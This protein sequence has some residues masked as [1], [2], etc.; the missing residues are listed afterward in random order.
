MASNCL[1]LLNNLIITF[2]NTIHTPFS[3]DF[4]KITELSTG[5]YGETIEIE[6]LFTECIC[7]KKLKK[8]FATNLH[9]ER[10][11][12]CDLCNTTVKN[13][14]TFWRCTEESDS[15]HKEGYTICDC[16]IIR[17]CDGNIKHCPYYTRLSS[18]IHAYNKDIMQTEIQINSTN[19]LQIQNDYLHLLET[20]QSD[21]EWEFIA[22]CL[23]YCDISE[24]VMFRRNN[25]NRNIFH[26]TDNKTNG[27]Y[28]NNVFSEIMDKIHCCF[29]HCYDIGHRLLIDERY[30]IEK[31]QTCNVF[32][33]NVSIQ[34]LL[35]SNQLLKINK[36]LSCK[37]KL[38]ERLYAG[39]L[40]VK[41]DQLMTEI[42]ESK[43]DDN[44]QQSMYCFGIRFNYGEN[45]DW[46]GDISV[47]PKYSSLKSEM[48][49]NSFCS[50]TI[51]QFNNE[52]NKA[53]I[54]FASFYC[55][56]HFAPQRIYD[57]QEYKYFKIEYLLS[58]MIYCNFDTLQNVFSK[59]Y[60]ENNGA[61]H[62]EF[63]HLGKYLKMATKKFGTSRKY[64]SEG[65]R[66]QFHHGISEKLFFPQ[67]FQNLMINGPLSTTTDILVAYNFTNNNKGLVV[68][69]VRYL[70][71]GMGHTTSAPKYFSCDWLSDFPSEKECLFIQEWE[72][73]TINNIIDVKIACEYKSI[74]TAMEKIDRAFESAIHV[75]EIAKDIQILVKAVINHQLS[76]STIKTLEKYG[77]NLI[78]TYF[79]NRTRVTIW[80][81]EIVNNKHISCA[82]EIFLHSTFKWVKLK[83]INLL[84]PKLKYIECWH[85]TFSH[86][87]LDDV[88]SNVDYFNLQTICIVIGEVDNA[89]KPQC[90]GSHGLCKFSTPHEGYGCDV[91][92]DT[93]RAN[94]DMWGCRVCNY[95]LCERCYE[96]ENK[97]FNTYAAIKICKQYSDRF[98]KNGL[99]I[100][101]YENSRLYIDKLDV[102]VYSLKWIEREKLA[103]FDN[104]GT[105]LHQPT[106]TLIEA[107]LSGNDNMKHKLFNDWC[108]HKGSFSIDWE[109]MNQPNNS[110]L[111]SILC[112]KEY[113]WIKIKKINLLFPNL[114]HLSVSGIKLC[115]STIINILEHLDDKNTKLEAITIDYT[116]DDESYCSDTIVLQ[117]NKQFEEKG[118]QIEKKTT[119]NC[120]NKHSKYA[121]RIAKI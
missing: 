27:D 116:N 67:Y 49:K 22:K 86:L 70:A 45:P 60:R 59:T 82:L 73:L 39:R 41:Y 97:K 96:K 111:L 11:V 68:T 47:S 115:T 81:D 1:R 85:T 83:E 16:C 110:H 69:F 64:D 84:Y 77:T 33:D 72:K 43:S 58:L 78:R 119:R 71:G 17:Y 34:Q 99:F 93:M 102:L 109:V 23:G 66:Q 108:L 15:V 101:F 94:R 103:Y 28:C 12:R 29:Q 7:G 46:Y 105:E 48:V 6:P 20:H 13:N 65:Y 91:C 100:A 87:V 61:D 121:V 95:D 4:I 88:L 50:L 107:Q 114:G 37:R 76:V 53:Q 56:K 55:K 92:N 51:D 117:Y 32:N 3:D 42:S 113:E 112:C 14:N 52:Y 118:W 63:Y 8:F 89:A 30:L 57:H 25:R 74:L 79:E 19:I 24:C 35:T 2:S 98:R 44:S 106:R 5:H 18:I 38:S 10:T 104:I 9:K 31:E 26:D 40:R 120:W 80:F 36:I 54:N 90:P 75:E 62:T 21:E